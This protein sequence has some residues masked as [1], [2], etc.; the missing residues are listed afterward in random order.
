MRRR[1]SM[2]VAHYLERTD[3]CLSRKGK[4]LSVDDALAWTRQP[5]PDAVETLLQENDLPRP[6]P[7]SFDKEVPEAILDPSVLL[8]KT[9]DVNSGDVYDDLPPLHC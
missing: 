6:D 3:G 2:A 1:F 7:Q 9:A 8:R 4:R 5:Q